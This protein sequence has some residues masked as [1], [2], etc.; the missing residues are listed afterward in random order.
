MTQRLPWERAM[1]TSGSAILDKCSVSLR[2]VD[3]KMPDA[4][5]C[6]PDKSK[7]QIVAWYVALKRHRIVRDQ[8]SLVLIETEGA[9][10]R[11]RNQ[12]RTLHTLYFPCLNADDIGIKKFVNRGL[13]SHKAVHSVQHLSSRKMFAVL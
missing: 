13:P 7:C 12:Y 5:Q 3:L 10:L 4:V 1:H 6:T 8:R 2:L 11:G 9:Q